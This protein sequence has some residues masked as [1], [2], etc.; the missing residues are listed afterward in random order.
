MSSYRSKPLHTIREDALAAVFSVI[1]NFLLFSGFMVMGYQDEEVKEPLED[2]QWVSLTAL[3]ENMPKAL[4]R[5]IAPD[6]ALTPS[7]EALSVSRVKEE[8]KPENKKEKQVKKEP[9]K[10]PKKKIKKRIKKKRK[11]K[12]GT[13]ESLFAKDERADR[14][15]RRGDV[16]GHVSGTSSQ[17][18]NST[19]MA[20]YLNR[21]S[22]LIQRR[23][24]LPAT[25]SANQLKRLSTTL[26]IR[27]NSKGKI[28][29]KPKWIKRS[30]NKFYDNASLRAL[31][32]FSSDQGVAKL[33][34]PRDK[35][36]RKT[37]LKKGFNIVLEGKKIR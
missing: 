7:S 20:I 11:P 1:V 28:I 35:K 33:I 26:F 2:V 13:L 32:P 25:L 34:L 31:D 30:G 24:R 27:I 14:G 19:E 36:L 37:V 5:I 9:K 8:K 18:K 17:W 10:E 6:E 15:K 22:T 12:K 4:P 29:G 23:V 3:G 16:R 21:V